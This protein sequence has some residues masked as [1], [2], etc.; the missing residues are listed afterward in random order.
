MI[1]LTLWLLQEAMRKIHN[2]GSLDQQRKA[3]L[4]QNIM[5]SK[6]IVA[7]QRRMHA[8]SSCEHGIRSYADA[9][10]SVLGCSHYWRG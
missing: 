8:S 6:Y 7:Q 9:G 4:S 10:Q 3:Y 1:Q 2:D 5:A